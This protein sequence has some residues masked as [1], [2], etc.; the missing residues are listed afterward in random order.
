MKA[1]I[2]KPDKRLSVDIPG[3]GGHIAA[4]QRPGGEIPWSRGDKSDPWDHIEAAMGLTI[5]GYHGRARKAFAWLKQKQTPQGSWYAE[6]RAGQPVQMRQDANMSAYIAVGL[7]H[8]YRITGDKA[9]LRSIWA[10]LD[11]AMG[12]VLGLQANSGEIYWAISPEGKTDP[13]ALL[14][15]SSSVFMSLKCAGAIARIL[16][17]DRPAWTEARHRLGAAIAGHPHL[18]NMTKS[19]YSMDW[20]Y[21]VLCGAVT[22][23]AARQRVARYWKKFVIQDQGVRCV[24]DQP[25]VTIAETA[26]LCLALHAMGDRELARIVFSWIGDK[27][28]PD[29]NYWCG[30]TFPEM[31][32]WPTERI[33]WTNAVVM[34]AADALYG[35]TPAAELFSHRFWDAHP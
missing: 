27:T 9:F 28:Y 33:S 15:G 22:G 30:H 35:L 1:E 17:K 7:Y 26:E 31:A 14:T 12:F 11:R 20:F 8:Y 24:S 6:Y 16:G 32:I 4:V 13:M 29:G 21:P 5:A 3:L 2:L 25:W 10:C 34:M 18:F 19:R 23:P